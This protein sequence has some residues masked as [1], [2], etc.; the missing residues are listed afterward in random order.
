[1]L[2][3]DSGM[4]GK[5]VFTALLAVVVQHIFR[6]LFA[7]DI[8]RSVNYHH[9]PGPCR[10][11]M[12]EN[13]SEDITV[14]ANGIALISS[15][16]YEKVGQIKM[17]DLIDPHSE[18]MD[19]IIEGGYDIKEFMVKPH[20]LSVWKDENTG[21][22]TVA[23]ITHP[24]SS[25]DR[26]EMFNFSPYCRVLKHVRSITD[27]AFYNLNDLVLVGQNSFYV[28]KTH[29]LRKSWRTVETILMFKWGEILY[30][31]GKTVQTVASKL[32]FPNGI[33]MSP[34]GSHIYMAEFMSS[35]VLVYSRNKDNSLNLE[36]SVYLDSHVDNIEVDPKT[37]ELWIGSHII[38]YAIATVLDAFE[39]NKEEARHMISPSQVFKLKTERGLI[40]DAT[41]VYL[42][43]GT[44]ITGSSV[45]A[46]YG[47][48]MIIGSIA[49]E[50]VVCEL[51]Y[52]E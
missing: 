42:N 26:I 8:H 50:T 27:P 44:E 49:S 30:Y 29:K 4:F 36:Q 17:I 48:R 20:G 12:K 24:D 35:T 45:A 34:S 6:V 39:S 40:V 43:N 23:V 28:T 37:G 14:L 7:L 1:M 11:V 32:S 5:V 21:S 18:V 31:D 25:D 47:N 15:S 3:F 51:V 10:Q 19:V 13:G 22:V 38:L 46:V 52:V 41:E 9:S 2:I 33:N 16:L